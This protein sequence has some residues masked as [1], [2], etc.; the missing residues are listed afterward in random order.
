[1]SD[2]VTVME[3]REAAGAAAADVVLQQAGQAGGG[4]LAARQHEAFCAALTGWSGGDPLSA[5]EAYL[6]AYPRSSRAAAR[7]NAARLL[8]RPDIAARVRWLRSTLAEATTV[9]FPGLNGTI[10]GFGHQKPNDWGLGLELRGHKSPHWTGTQSS[11]ATFG[12]FGQSGTFLWVDPDAGLAA[13][14]LTDRDF[15][16]WARPRWP[17]L[18]DAVLDAATRRHRMDDA[19]GG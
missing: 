19:L 4:A 14:V 15:G 12:H 1:M 3:E 16:D 10:P 8:A 18:S 5:T 7:A 6:A 13:V 9:Q 2:L 17:E 11:P